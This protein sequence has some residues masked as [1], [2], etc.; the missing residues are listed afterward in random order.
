MP[1]LGI[2]YRKD[3]DWRMESNK[4]GNALDTELGALIR[5]SQNEREFGVLVCD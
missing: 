5:S 4:M 3:F 1:V 2:V